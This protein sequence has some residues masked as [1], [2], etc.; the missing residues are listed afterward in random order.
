MGNLRRW[1]II[2]GVILLV[3]VGF[4]VLRGPTPTIELAPESLVTFGQFDDQ[5]KEIPEALPTKINDIFNLAEGLQPKITNS[6]VTSWAA[7]AILI[8]LAIVATRRVSLVPSG[9]QNLVEAV[10]EWFLR[11]VEGVAGEKNGRR[12]FPVVMTIFLYILVANWLA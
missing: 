3:G 4:L 2:G 12:F 8:V 7:V 1:L 5:L 10:L 6:M 9:L 11:L